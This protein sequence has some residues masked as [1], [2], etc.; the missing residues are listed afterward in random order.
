MALKATIF[1]A[2][3]QIADLDRD[4]Y[5]EHSLT[6]ARHPSET[7]ERLMVRLV[8]FILNAHDDL[9]FGRGLSNEDEAALWQKDLTGAIDTWIEVG[10]PDER[11]L[12]KAAGRARK[13]RVYS[14]G[15]SAASIWWQQNRAALARLP[16]LE[17]FDL[18]PGTTEA[19]AAAAERT[20]IWQATVSE[21]QLFLTGGD[22]SLSASPIR[23]DPNLV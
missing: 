6:L 21:G 18:D 19:L 2:T 7:N 1:K 22:L 3:V 20:M 14:Y 8:A 15:G 5:A 16:M 4:Y 10:L 23:R 9:E 11:V 12:R 13:I 17:V